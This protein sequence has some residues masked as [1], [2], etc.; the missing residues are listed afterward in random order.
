MTTV[1]LD[2]YKMQLIRDIL[3]IDSEEVLDGLM[4][5]IHKNRQ[6]II[7]RKYTEKEICEMIDKSEEE[8]SAGRTIA[9]DVAHRNMRKFIESL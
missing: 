7:S 8:I 1:E 3:A 2:A 6:K 4:C 5:F 9:S